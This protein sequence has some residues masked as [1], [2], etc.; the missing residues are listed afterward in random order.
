MVFQEVLAKPALGKARGVVVGGGKAVD[1]LVEGNARVR[2]TVGDMDTEIRMALEE[3]VEEEV[4]AS[5]GGLAGAD[6]R[7]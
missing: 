3:V 1:L 6:V 7:F 5:G 4:N 2:W